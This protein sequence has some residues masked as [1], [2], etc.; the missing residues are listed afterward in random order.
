FD[1]L[2][3]TIV[4]PQIAIFLIIPTRIEIINKPRCPLTIPDCLVLKDKNGK[5]LTHIGMS[6][7]ICRISDTL[8]AR[9]AK[10]ALPDELFERYRQHPAYQRFIARARRAGKQRGDR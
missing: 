3:S 7:E 1:L 5:E 10:I 9:D 2:N 6:T 8:G 4:L